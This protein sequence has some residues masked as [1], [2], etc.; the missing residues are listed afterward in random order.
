VINLRMWATFGNIL[1][2]NAVL[3]LIGAALGVQS[4]L[5]LLRTHRSDDLVLIIGTLSAAMVVI[6]VLYWLAKPA[7]VSGR[8]FFVRWLVGLYMA[9]WVFSSLGFALIIIGVFYLFTGEP[10]IEERRWRSP[11]APAAPRYRKPI[12]WQPSGKVGPSGAMVY[13]DP[14]RTDHLGLIDSGIPVQVTD[15]RDGY[16]RVVAATGFAG[17]IDNRTLVRIM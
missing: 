1:R 11:E 7:L 14:Q 4:T 9:L 12:N 16:A 17:W 3:G 13:S 15:E 2:I 8:P 6:A 10:D 5:D